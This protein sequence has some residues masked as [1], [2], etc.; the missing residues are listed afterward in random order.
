MFLNTSA[1]VVGA[2]LQTRKRPSR[3]QHDPAPRQ[4]SPRCTASRRVA[5]MAARRARAHRSS[6][7]KQGWMM[8]FMSK[9]KLSHSRPLGLG[10]EKSG[11][12]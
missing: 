4:R 9:Y 11:G 2:G 10:C 6:G 12:T 8:P 7:W 3:P 1:T 5:Q